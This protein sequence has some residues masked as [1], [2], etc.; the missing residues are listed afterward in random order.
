MHQKK[1][2]HNNRRG[3]SSSRRHESHVEQRMSQKNSATKW[4][5]L[6]K[7]LALAEE[8]VLSE[9]VALKTHVRRSR[10]LR[11]ELNGLTQRLEEMEDKLTT[12]SDSEHHSLKVLQGQLDTV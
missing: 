4:A 9:Q 7:Q 2:K 8:R 6:E 1:D 12:V 3:S 11:T 5:T 10:G